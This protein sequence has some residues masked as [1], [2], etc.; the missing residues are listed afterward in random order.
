VTI[1]STSVDRAELP[2]TTIQLRAE[3][4]VMLARQRARRIAQGLGLDHQD[5]VR[6][7]TALSELARNAFQYA[8]GG[9]VAFGVRREEP[10]SLLF[11]RVTDD[12]PGIGNLS[13]ILAGAY[14]SRTGMGVGIT[15]ARRLADRF[16]IASAPG[17]GTQVTVAKTLPHLTGALV[18]AQVER[19][20]DALTR[21]AAASPF[22]EL[23]R[24]NLDL[25]AALDA[26]REREA[27]AVRLGQELVDTNRG[28]VALY[29][30]LDDRAQQLA[31]MS[32]AKTRFLSDVSHE[33]RTPLSSIVNLTRLLLS[34]VDGPLGSEQE[35]QVQ[36]IH[37]SA[38]WLA[39][40]VNELLDVAKIESGK[41]ELRPDEFTVLELFATLRA[42]LRPLATNDGVALVVE[43]AAEPIAMYTDE[44]R[45]AQVLRN[46]VSNALKF[47]LA[48]E[49]R[50]SAAVEDGTMVRFT[51]SD[52]GIGIAPADQQKVF[53]DFVQ[54]DGPIQRR[55]RGTGL[56][57]PLTRKLA[58]I[59]GG[60]VHLASEV[61]RGSTFSLVIPRDVRTAEVLHG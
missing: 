32:E 50:L 59:L 18:V 21:E 29:A 4:D 17:R 10:V 5:Q 41:V 2:I 7:A 52:T 57:L 34:H 46:F 61:G 9:R 24:Q 58:R 40:M 31:R 12:G 44:Q 36:M 22:A 39:E 35:K 11:A 48:G 26:V 38:E 28:V 55:V 42:M 33:L 15:G 1:P 51:V 37:R 25:L 45:I 53:E 3:D 8:R 20:A 43:D 19:V 14:V 6:F 13:T 27:D 60:E 56:G 49:V 47:T 23:E 54:V 16:D 30:E